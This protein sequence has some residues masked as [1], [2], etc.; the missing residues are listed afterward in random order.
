MTQFTVSSG[1]PAGEK[2]GRPP[3]GPWCPPIRFVIP[4]LVHD[5]EGARLTA[6]YLSPALLAESWPKHRAGEAK[7]PG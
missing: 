5:T 6:T 4:E 2:G 7:R 1:S 3:Y